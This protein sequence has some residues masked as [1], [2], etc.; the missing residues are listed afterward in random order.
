MPKP[1][2]KK[3]R[4]P[5]KKKLTRNLKRRNN[6]SFPIVFKKAVP[7]GAAFFMGDL[8]EVFRQMPEFWTKKGPETFGVLRTNGGNRGCVVIN[9]PKLATNCK[10]KTTI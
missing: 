10:Q 5:Q 8:M 3:R 7:K 4:L 1:R 9:M 6:R 2:K